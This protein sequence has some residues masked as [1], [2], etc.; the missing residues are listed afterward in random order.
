[1]DFRNSLTAE[2]PDP[3][4]DEPDGLRADIVDELAD[5]LACAYRRELMRGADPTTARGRVLERFGDPA[6]LAGRLW[7]DAMRGKI[8]SKR[9][10]VGYSILLTVL[11]LGLV[12]LNVI[13]TARVQRQYAQ[14]LMAER[15]ARMRQMEAQEKML[16]QIEA[17][18][19]ATTAARMPDWIP[20]KFHL[21]QDEPSG[22]PV[23]GA[24]VRLGRGTNGSR[25]ADAIIRQSD[26]A[27]TVDLGVIQPGDWSFAVTF[28]G[29]GEY[30]GTSGTLNVIP[31]QTIE[32]EIVCPKTP[33]EESTVHVQL[34]WPEDLAGQKLVIEASLSF[35]GLK[36]DDALLWG[37]GRENWSVLCESGRM[38]AR[39]P[40]RDLYPWRVAVLENEKARPTSPIILSVDHPSQNQ[41]AI[42][43][44]RGKYSLQRLMI[45]RPATETP[46]ANHGAWYE[47][48][49]FWSSTAVPLDV[50]YYDRFPDTLLKSEKII[51]ALG[52]ENLFP[53]QLSPREWSRWNSSFVAQPGQPNDWT[54]AIPDEL[55]EAVR[56]K[57][58]VAADAK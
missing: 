53:V 30:W 23:A 52:S 16:Q 13:Q 31:G 11:C 36:L 6:A 41:S 38:L 26:A 2:L 29:S 8:M 56:A 42:T 45:L 5:H 3:R 19:K 57:L 17:V 10:L 58:K 44:K 51:R 12:G 50:R 49:S 32:R 33:V 40:A 48:L 14:A 55:A 28:S 35:E 9:I 47:I 43:W 4:D 37:G 7:F 18:A 25:G 46:A 22:P 15:E 24:Q 54:I 1:M 20:V 39:F 27:G 34:Q 21:V